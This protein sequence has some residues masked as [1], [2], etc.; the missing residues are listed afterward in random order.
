MYLPHLLS[1]NWVYCSLHHTRL[2]IKLLFFLFFL[3]GGRSGSVVV[4]LT[5]DQGAVGSSPTGVTALCP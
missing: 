3:E 2:I 4:C 5:R 1:A